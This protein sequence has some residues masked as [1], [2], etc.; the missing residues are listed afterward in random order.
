LPGRANLPWMPSFLASP[1]LELRHRAGTYG[2]H[3]LSS[4][5][6]S[7]SLGGRCLGCATHLP[8]DPKLHLMRPPPNWRRPVAGECKNPS[9]MVA[10]LVPSPF[11]FVL[12]SLWLR[13][14]LLPYCIPLS[15]CVSV[16]DSALFVLNSALLH[17]LSA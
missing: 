9:I 2:H 12:V 11:L 5:T 17:A 7:S 16:R 1:A 13:A 10:R 14:S 6:S 3:S 4:V 8:L 15:A